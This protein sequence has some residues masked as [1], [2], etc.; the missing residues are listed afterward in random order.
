MTLKL[1]HSF[2][3]SDTETLAKNLLGKV[4]V[5]KVSGKFLKGII[6]EVEVYTEEDAASHCFGGRKT[7]RNSVMFKRAGHLY[8]YFIYGI[9]YCLNI[10]SDEENF[11]SAV[12]IRSLIPLENICGEVDGPAKL[13]KALNI[14]TEQNGVCLVTSDEIYLEDLGYVPK[15]I[16]FRKRVGISKEKEKLLR[17]CADFDV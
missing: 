1:R 13:C 7:Q 11:G 17:F 2:Y 10:V 9:H 3:M 4:F 8:V 5:R 15:N 12:L 14:T 6:N 16:D